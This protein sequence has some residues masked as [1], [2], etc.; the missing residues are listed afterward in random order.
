MG[1]LS[2]LYSDA[3]HDLRFT[4]RTFRRSPGFAVVA[5]LTLALGIGAN[6]AV[7]RI[8]D[9]VLI[10]MLPVPEPERLIQILQPDAAPAR[11]TGEYFP[12]RR[13]L[14][15]FSFANFRE[16]QQAAAQLAGWLPTHHQIPRTL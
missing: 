3:T 6:T 5:I 12:G 11:S 9:A 1:L 10:R 15:R 13:Y 4:V 14:D 8:A 16:M 2:R 7:F